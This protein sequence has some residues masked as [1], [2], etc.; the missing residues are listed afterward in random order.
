M[1]VVI[2]AMLFVTLIA[3]AVVVYVAYPHRGEQLPYVPKLGEAMGKA[4]EALPTLDDDAAPAGR[5]R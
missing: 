1:T 3:A 4:V 5:R 2:V